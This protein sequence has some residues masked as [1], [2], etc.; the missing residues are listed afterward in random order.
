M[1][2][3][4]KRKILFVDDERRW[5]D[6]VSASLAGAGFAILAVAD[7]SQAMREAEDPALGLIL[8]DRDLA[9]ESGVMLS[10]FL[11]CNHPEVRTVMYASPEPGPHRIFGS[12]PPGRDDWLAKGSMEELVAQVGHYIKQVRRTFALDDSPL[13][14]VRPG[15]RPGVRSPMERADIRPLGTCGPQ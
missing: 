1:N 10:R 6:R 3:I 8:V 2:R 5:R 4:T 7:A 11:R 13:D 14:G 15:G 9:G 12:S